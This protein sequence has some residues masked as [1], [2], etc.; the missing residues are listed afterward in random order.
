MSKHTEILRAKKCRERVRFLNN[1][2]LE[3][4]LFG[5]VGHSLDWFCH[6]V[7]PEL[8]V[9]PVFHLRITKV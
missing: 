1:S 4:C 6:N 9:Y 5:H 2:P 8:W 3:L 7:L